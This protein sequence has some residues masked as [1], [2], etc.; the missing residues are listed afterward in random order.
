M[1]LVCGPDTSILLKI[2]DDSKTFYEITYWVLNAESLKKG[3]KERFYY[4]KSLTKSCTDGT[5]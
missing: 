2:A 5:H 3:D 4:T 1:T